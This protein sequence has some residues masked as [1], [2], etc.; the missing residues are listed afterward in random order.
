V[1]TVEDETKLW[2][3]WVIA[4]GGLNALLSVFFLALLVAHADESFL[5]INEPLFVGAHPAHALSDDT[6]MA[7]S[8]GFGLF[9]GWSVAIAWTYAIVPASALGPV[10]KA[11]LGGTV[12]WYA[13]DS[14]GSIV[15]HAPWNAALNTV[16]F[17]LIVIPL[18]AL[19]RTGRRARA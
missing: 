14:V 3:R 19:I 10:S 12:V 2:R 9:G 13:L 4:I 11:L 18:V 16:Y 15:S 5:A 8:I 6:R 7:Q 1:P 17:V